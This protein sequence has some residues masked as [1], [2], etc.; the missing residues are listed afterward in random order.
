MSA[1]LMYTPPLRVS[2]AIN[3]KVKDIKIEN[4]SPEVQTC[5]YA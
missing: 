4:T 5:R 3:V 2:E 1:L